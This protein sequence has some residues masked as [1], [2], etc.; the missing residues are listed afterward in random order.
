MV[1]LIK[2][3]MHQFLIN[4]EEERCLKKEEEARLQGKPHKKE[5]RRKIDPPQ[6]RMGP[7][8]LCQDPELL[9]MVNEYDYEL[10]DKSFQT[11]CEN[12]GILY[13]AGDIGSKRW[14]FFLH[15]HKNKDEYLK[16]PYFQFAEEVA[17][18]KYKYTAK[19]MET[20]WEIIRL[21][22]AKFQDCWELYSQHGHN[23]GTSTNF[24]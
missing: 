7:K 10:S 20:G 2:D 1:P 14:Q 13:I 24:L 12:R 21:G 3:Q 23:Q 4:K 9:L 6:E 15:W 5:K 16:D 18:K 19:E 8:A 11:Y 22:R 17:G